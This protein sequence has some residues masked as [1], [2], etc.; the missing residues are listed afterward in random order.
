MRKLISVILCLTALLLLGYSGYRSY[1][2]WKQKHLMSMA[3]Q[4]AAKSDL[5]NARLSAMPFR[6]S[7]YLSWDASL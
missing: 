7:H 1:S 5:G 6:N 3:R 4:F 2:T